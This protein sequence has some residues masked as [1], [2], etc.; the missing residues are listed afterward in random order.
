MI[1][2]VPW[3]VTG[4]PEESSPGGIPIRTCVGCRTRDPQDRLLRV[5]AVAG[6][7]TPDPSRRLPG[8]GAY[9]HPRPECLALAERKRV[10]ARA[11]RLSGPA[12]LGSVRAGIDQ[13]AADGRP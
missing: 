9:L 12:E 4:L 7:P 1:C 5:V 11:L 10:F 13:V 2:G 8:R 3:S 6:V